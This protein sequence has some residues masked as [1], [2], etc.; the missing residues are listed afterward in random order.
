MPYCWLEFS[1]H[2]EGPATGQLDQDFRV[3]PWSQSKCWVGTQIPRC[4]ACFSCSPPNG[5]IKFSPYTDVP[6]TSGCSWGIWVREPYTGKKESHCQPK[7]LKS[8]HEPHWGPGT[9]TNLVTDRRTKYCITWNWTCVIALKITDPSS[10]QRGSSKSTTPQLSK[11][12]QRE[13]GENWSWVPDGCLTPRQ[14]VGRNITFTLKTHVLLLPHFQGN[15]LLPHIHWNASAMERLLRASFLATGAYNNIYIYIYTHTLVYIVWGVRV[16][17]WE[18]CV[19]FS[20]EK[21]TNEKWS[22][23]KWGEKCSFS[24]SEKNSKLI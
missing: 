23:V 18:V 21:L 5:N 6:L 17:K 3:F 8:R 24:Y 15:M 20:D 2:P 10:R 14:T 11:S 7:K 22:R 19:F 16:K 9:K 12:N 13:K 1:L 4:T